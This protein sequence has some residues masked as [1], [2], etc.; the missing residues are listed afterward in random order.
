MINNVIGF[1]LKADIYDMSGKLINTNLK[2]VYPKDFNRVEP[3]PL[4]KKFFT[5]FNEGLLAKVL[6]YKRING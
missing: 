6:D 4:N 5:S 2:T 1:N 3:K